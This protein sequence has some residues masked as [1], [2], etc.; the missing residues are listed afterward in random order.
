MTAIITGCNRGIGRCL[1]ETFAEHGANIFACVREEST[2]FDELM[3][4]IRIENGVSITPVYFNLEDPN[5]VK[6]AVRTIISHKQNIDILVNNAGIAS[7]S[8]FQMTSSTELDRSMQINFTSQILFSQGLSRFM[9]RQK[10]GSI[11]NI[12]SVAGIIGDAGT[13]S[14]GASKAALM[15]ATKTMAT[16]LGVSNIRVNAIAPGI[17]LTDMFE[18]MDKT[19]R[20]RMI[21][22]SALKRAAQP[23]E[24]ANVAL[25]LASDLSSFITGQT[26]RVDGGML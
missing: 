3:N 11:I 22:S 4:A 14:Y 17:T 12:A 25:F 9:S 8:I 18:Q 13:L 5:Q 26:I 2:E 10:K 16:E 1:F 6:A 24:I 21:D 15:F 23:R 7:G 19:A 20:D